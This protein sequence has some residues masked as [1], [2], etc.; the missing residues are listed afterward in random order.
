MN[1]LF[2]MY[3]FDYQTVY[4]HRI[5]FFDNKAIRIDSVKFE[6]ND[7]I[8]YPIKSIREQNYRC[9][10]PYG[11]SFLGEKIV[12]KDNWN[13]FFNEQGDTIKI[14]TDAILNESFELFHIE[15][16]V[17]AIAT[18][19]SIEIQEFLGLSDSVKT[20]KIEL[21]DK[22]GNPILNENPIIKISKNY[23][24]VQTFNFYDFYFSVY[25]CSYC[26]AYE[27]HSLLGLTNPEVGQQNLTWF[28]VFDFQP[29]DELHTVEE[30]NDS[31]GP[32]ESRTSIIEKY[33]SRTD[34]GNDS[35]SY[36]VLKTQHYY[37]RNNAGE[38][39]EN[40]NSQNVTYTYKPNPEFDRLNGEP[41]IH[42]DDYGNGS[43]YAMMD[44]SS[45]KSIPNEVQSIYNYGS[46]EC[47]QQYTWDG[48]F[49]D[50]D[51]YKGL[52]GPYHSLCYGF[53][54]SPYEKKLVYYKKGDETWGIPLVITSINQIIEKEKNLIINNPVEEIIL[55]NREMIEQSCLFELIDL[56]GRLILQKNVDSNNSTLN[57]NHIQ[58]G[59]YLC[60]LIKNNQVFTGKVI[61]RHFP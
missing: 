52:G 10:T 60:R 2:S 58:N 5:A 18:V 15:D 55:L 25:N 47:W 37:L 36:N 33:Q 14:K 1:S 7:S 26:P 19:I 13:Y 12:I 28:E 51:Y 20:I 23:G 11:A 46:D 61:I 45:G 3:A 44:L 22:E 9:F 53:D 35:I 24:F 56:N 34:Y 39:T 16:S 50:N 27:K 4:S 42:Y 49:S 48:C 54:G 8:F 29:G 40:T 17:L 32:T 38:V 31:W 30:Y 59:L 41:I 57:I 43:A 6:G 21:F